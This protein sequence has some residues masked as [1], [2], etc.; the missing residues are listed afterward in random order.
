[1]IEQKSRPRN[2]IECRTAAKQ[3]RSAL[4]NFGYGAGTARDIVRNLV[5]QYTLRTRQS[6]PDMI[7]GVGEPRPVTP[8]NIRIFIL[9]LVITRLIWQRLKSANW[10]ADYV[11]RAGFV[12]E[13]CMCHF[14]EPRYKEEQ[15]RSHKVNI[16]PVVL[17]RRRNLGPEPA[18]TRSVFVGPLVIAVERRPHLQAV[19]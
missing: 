4:P 5:F 12:M 19:I 16:S 15:P 8:G 7:I 17:S 3:T 9:L 14:R 1:L 11:T 13:L 10:G 18:K 2:G 6:L